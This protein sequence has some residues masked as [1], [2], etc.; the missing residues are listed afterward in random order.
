MVDKHTE[1]GRRFAFQGM[2]EE[3]R[4]TLLRELDYRREAVNLVTLANNLRDY[5]RLVD[6]AAGRRLHDLARA[7]HGL[8]QGDEDHR[9]LARSPASTSTTRRSPRT[10]ARPISTRS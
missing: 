9:S 7:D 1:I 3:F 2:L 5:Q 10:S 4:K 8:R 6:P